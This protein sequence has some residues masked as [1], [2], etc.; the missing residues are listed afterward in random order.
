MLKVFIKTFT[1]TDSLIKNCLCICVCV[2]PFNS[3]S[4]TT[5]EEKEK[6]NTYVHVQYV[7]PLRDKT[8]GSDDGGVGKTELHHFT[9]QKHDSKGLITS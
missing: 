4:L 2:S 9:Y 6:S 5:G 7:W 1:K 3:V 8:F